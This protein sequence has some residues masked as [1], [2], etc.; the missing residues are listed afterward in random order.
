MDLDEHVVG[1]GGGL[2]DVVDDDVEGTG[3][4]D[5]LGCAHGSEAS[6]TYSGSTIA[7]ISKCMGSV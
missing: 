1:T 7:F 2:G 4:R 3:G 6:G 5:D